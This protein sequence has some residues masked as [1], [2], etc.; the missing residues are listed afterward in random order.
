MLRF[1][2]LY[3]ILVEIITTYKLNL[4]FGLTNYTSN[5]RLKGRMDEFNEPASSFD[6]IFLTTNNNNS[7]NNLLQF[8]LIE[9]VG[10]N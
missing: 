6:C 1:V 4:I 7:K 9:V 3:C 8:I 5:C 2:F 10:S